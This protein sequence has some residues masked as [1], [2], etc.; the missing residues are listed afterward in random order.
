ME[1]SAA[2]APRI[3]NKLRTTMDCVVLLNPEW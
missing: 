1:P 3:A 2:A